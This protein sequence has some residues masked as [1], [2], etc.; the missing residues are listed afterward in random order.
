MTEP[1]ELAQRQDAIIE[2]IKQVFPKNLATKGKKRLKITQG[3]S[4]YS[5]RKLI[6][7]FEG[8]QWEDMI[9]YQGI[10]YYLSDVD[11]MRAISDKAYRY[12]LPTFLVA[13]LKEPSAWVYTSN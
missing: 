10:V 7:I 13:T 8:K 9:A 2:R 5:S 1:D 3:R 12:F 11:Y 6:E 4:D